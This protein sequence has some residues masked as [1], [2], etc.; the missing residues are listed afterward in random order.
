MNVTHL[1]TYTNQPSK[2]NLYQNRNAQTVYEVSWKK[3]SNKNDFFNPKEMSPTKKIHHKK[4][5]WT[6]VKTFHVKTFTRIYTSHLNDK[7]NIYKID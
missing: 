2:W 1:H 7:K 6:P 4:K 5:H 3:H